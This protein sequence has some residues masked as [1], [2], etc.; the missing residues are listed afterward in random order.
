MNKTSIVSLSAV[1]IL[2][3]MFHISNG[4]APR[5]R[6]D[7][8]VAQPWEYKV[9][10]FQANPAGSVDKLNQMSLEG[11]EYVGLIH[12]GT[13]RSPNSSIA[14]RRLRIQSPRELRR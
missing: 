9:V 7:T 14:F 12:P 3:L 6:R 13:D 8:V 2:G 5:L 11:W 10:L 4:Q 1:V